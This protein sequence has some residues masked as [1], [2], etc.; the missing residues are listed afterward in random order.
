MRVSA[1]FDSKMI[2]LGGYFIH[3]LPVVP[4][5]PPARRMR[6]CQIWQYILQMRLTQKMKDNDNEQEFSIR[7]F[8][9]G[10]ETHS[11]RVNEV[12]S[13]SVDMQ[14][15]CVFNGSTIAEL[16]VRCSPEKIEEIVILSL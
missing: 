2:L 14:A 9:L 3:I 4:R 10:N 7:F 13:Y 15:A 11:K 1:L 12:S 16:L 5:A 8:Q 6:K